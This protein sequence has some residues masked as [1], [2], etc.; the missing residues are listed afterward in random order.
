MKLDRR[1]YKRMYSC[2][3]T[4][5][6]YVIQARDSFALVQYLL[7]MKGNGN[8]KENVMCRSCGKNTFLSKRHKENNLKLPKEGLK[9]K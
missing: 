8:K 6:P 9:N 7:Y 4:Q 3:V 2:T 1:K 5:S